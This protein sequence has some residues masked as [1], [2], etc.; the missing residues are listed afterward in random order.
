MRLNSSK[1]PVFH[2]GCIYSPSQTRHPPSP[3]CFTWT[4]NGVLV[5]LIVL[6][7]I[8]CYSSVWHSHSCQNHLPEVQVRH[9][10]HLPWNI[11]RFRCWE[12]QPSACTSDS[13]TWPHKNGHWGLEHSSK[14]KERPK[15]V[16][17]LPPWVGIFLPVSAQRMFCCPWSMCIIWHLANFTIKCLSFT[18]RGQTG[19]FYYSTGEVGKLPCGSRGERAI[20]RGGPSPPPK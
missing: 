8:S 16:L 13:L 11:S 18:G 9:E 4:V 5:F 12:R 3:L 7:L 6:L 20:A 19:S 10:I 1:A 14:D 17:G 2:G 15:P